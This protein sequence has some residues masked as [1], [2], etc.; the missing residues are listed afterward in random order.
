M[1][2]P[3]RMAPVGRRMTGHVG[4][5]AAVAAGV[6]GDGRAVALTGGDDAAVRVWDL[7]ANVQI[8]VE[9]P[10]PTAVRA[11]AVDAGRPGFRIVMAGN[12]FLA[13]ADRR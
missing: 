11:L 2:D 4:Q 8:G 12:G 1:W 13:V 3:L 9:L 10:T 6:L 7:S 5:V